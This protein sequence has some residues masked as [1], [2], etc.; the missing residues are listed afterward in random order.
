MVL[1]F[2]TQEEILNSKKELWNDHR[3][4]LKPFV[5]RKTTPSRNCS[6]ANVLDILEAFADLDKSE[7]AQRVNYVAA[8]LAKL[9]SLHPEDINP[10]STARRISNVDQ[11]C[12]MLINNFS[13]GQILMDT[14]KE[15]LESLRDKVNTHEQLIESVAQQWTERSPLLG[16]ASEGADTR[17]DPGNN[18]AQAAE[19]PQDVNRITDGGRPVHSSVPP[20]NDSPAVAEYSELSSSSESEESAC[21]SCDEDKCSSCDE[22][23]SCVGSIRITESSDEESSPMPMVTR[24]EP[25]RPPG[26]T[27]PKQQMGAHHGFKRKGS[28]KFRPSHQVTETHRSLQRVRNTSSGNESHSRKTPDASRKAKQSYAHVV[29]RSWPNQR[30]NENGFLTPRDQWRKQWKRSSSVSLFVYNVP[31]SC[32]LDDVHDYVKERKLNF[33][34]LFQRSHPEAKRK[35]FVLKVSSVVSTKM[36][37]SEFWPAGTR[38]RVY[39]DKSVGA[40][41]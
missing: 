27:R 26:Q 39:E 8:N 41:H 24:Q 4:L 2:F 31:K 38:V 37:N 33:K 10:V 36:L 17:E 9:P 5:N 3:D 7:G 6:E 40:S 15:T 35:S 13:E 16:N 12:N 19:H 34:D 30:E 32:S 29:K 25:K 14:L 21:S 11:K 18:E 20:S 22:C 1:D 28:N 23:A